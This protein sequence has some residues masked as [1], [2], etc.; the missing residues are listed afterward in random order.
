MIIDTERRGWERRQARSAPLPRRALW[1]V[2]SSSP[3]YCSEVAGWR[4]YG[5]T[6]PGL[7]EPQEL[8][9]A[10]RWRWPSSGEKRP[11]SAT[12]GNDESPALR[13]GGGKG[14]VSFSLLRGD[15]L[16]RVRLGVQDL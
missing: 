12:G 1:M 9:I 2:R 7:V 10:S 6:T 15:V 11:F 8:P 5:V 3:G 14:I 13:G 16:G 4:K